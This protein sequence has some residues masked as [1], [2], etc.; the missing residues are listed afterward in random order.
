VGVINA[1]DGLFC[2]TV[3][4]LERLSSWR[5]LKPFAGINKIIHLQ[6]SVCCRQMNLLIL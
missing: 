3:I 1:P 6:R 2:S 4:S 5:T